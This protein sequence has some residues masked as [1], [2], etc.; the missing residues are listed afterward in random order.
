M[1]KTMSLNFYFSLKACFC[2]KR[3]RIV[4]NVRIDYILISFIYKKE[5]HRITCMY[6]ERLTDKK[7]VVSIKIIFYIVVVIPI[8]VATVHTIQNN[9]R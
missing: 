3:M 2:F 8:V 5:V 7:S 4:K 6:N 1:K 9:A